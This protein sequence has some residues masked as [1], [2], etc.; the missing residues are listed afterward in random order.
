VLSALAGA[1]IAHEAWSGNGPAASSGFAQLPSGGQFGQLSPGAGNQT[2]S[3]SSVASKVDPG[4]VDIDT[5][6]AIGGEAAGTGMVVTP[7]GEVITNNHVISESTTITATDIGN[8]RMYTGR[9]IGYDASRDVAVIQLEG[10]SR[11]PTVTLGHSSEVRVGQRVITIGNAGGV[12]GTPTAANG[13]VT[14][15]DRSITASDDVDQTSEQLHGLIELDGQLQPGDSGGP[16]VDA[17]GSVIG[18]DT[19]ASATFSFQSTTGQGFAI[20]IDTVA[21][22]AGQIVAGHAS[23][24]IH[25]GATALIGVDITSNPNV[26]PEQCG[27]VTPGP[28]YVAAVPQGGPAAAAGINPCDTITALDGHTVRSPEALVAIKDRFHPGDRVRITWIDNGIKHSATL[29][30]TVGPAD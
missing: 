17:S 29:R 6:L 24:T 3:V 11:L 30:L 14:G 22:L 13:S 10:A 23:N 19:A 9:V 27:N 5:Q 7:T 20:P 25:I 2:T 16:L 18:M 8:G 28:A 4:L 12:G 1:A 15:L 21:A 26:L